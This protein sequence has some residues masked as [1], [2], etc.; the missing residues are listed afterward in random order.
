[1]YSYTYDAQ[2]GGI[3]LN[4]TPTGFSKEPRPVYAQELNVLGF[5]KHWKYDQQNALP[6]M[7]AE[8]N[9][10]YYRGILV[11]K[12]KG[13]N[14][15]NA[16][17]IIIPTDDSGKPI[18]PEPRG[19][20]LR[21]IDIDAMVEANRDMLTIIEQTTVK[22]IISIYKK[23]RAKLD[24]FHVA[25][26]GGKDSQVLLDLVKKALPK[27]SFV[28]VFG[29][30]GME[31]PDT[32]DVVALTE[33]QCKA[34]GITFERA[35]SH[36]KPQQSWEMFGP[37]SRTLRWCCHVHKSAPQTFKLR[38][39][40]KKSDYTG[41]AFVGI[42]A[43]ESATRS[44]YD[45]FNDGKKIKGQFSHNSI[46]E[47]TSAEI[48]L[49]LYANKI[50]LNE[51]YRKGSAR[52][53]CLLCPMGG[54]GKSGYI[55]YSN[56]SNEVSQ[57]FDFIKKANGRKNADIDEIL[58]NGGWSARKNGRDLIN[59]P[60]KYSGKTENGCLTIEVS[61]P[62][63]NWKEWIK[64]VDI[65]PN[66]YAIKKAKTG[67][68][69]EIKESFIKENPL[70]GKYI[71][72]VFHKSAYCG[73]C[74]V[75]EA[76]CPNSA[77]KFVNGKVEINDCT[78]CKKCH[79]I[80]SGCLLYH[81]KHH[82]QG[83]GKT[84]NKSLN[85][86]SNHAPKTEWLTEF[87]ENKINFFKENSL[88]VKNQLGPFSR[89]LTDA[90]LI[91]NKKQVTLFEA[92][93]SSIGWQT[94][95]AQGLIYVNLVANNPQIEWYV[96]NLDIGRTY[97]REEVIEMLIANGVDKGTGKDPYSTHKSILY[98]FARLSEIP[99]G[100]VLNFGHITDSGE[101][102]RTKCTISDARVVLY[103]LFKFAEKCGDYKGFTLTTLL[104]DNIERDGISPTRI[105]GL[106][107]EDMQ[108]MLL[109]LSAKYP[110]F[111]NASFTHDMDKIT[112]AEDKTSQDV[113]DLF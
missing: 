109:G 91:D 48:W 6:Y 62:L 101:L 72:Q 63:S 33:Q 31:F 106:D 40:T 78:Q 36:L 18:K 76:N 22:K 24:C 11:A 87:F 75:C 41:L 57:Y 32:Y 90:C 74:K 29:D 34:E 93:V 66:D 97:S 21:A 69:V 59:N 45:F 35:E 98:A 56:Y 10:Y 82:P 110:E 85:T 9:H 46:L 28:V 102:V 105:F 94:D 92:I 44:E 60:N 58:C 23:Y 53:G 7:W 107:R 84:M 52:V 14:I 77:I 88:N 26:S 113:L 55:E 5:D 39:I 51:A 1:M 15:Y 19:K 68:F 20:K 12:L 111:I 81:S 73:R 80:D 64:T 38:E 83:G 17:E 96:A 4:S 37:P 61:D 25:F 99:L 42:R 13:G 71:K 27:G 112:L 2:T 65:A 47:W 54:G 104:N 89:F 3:L 103:A 100:T 70:V 95:M 49:Y 8:A 50:T 79:A 30:T 16:P 43:Y 67:Y 86:M 108:P